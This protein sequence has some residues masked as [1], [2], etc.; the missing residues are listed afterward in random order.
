MTKKMLLAAFVCCMGL[1]T[2]QQANANSWRVNSDKRANANFLDLNAAM[3]TVAEGDTIYVDKGCVIATEQTINKSVTIIGPG[4]FIGENDADEAFFSNVI[5][6]SA[7]NVKLTGLHTA[8]IY[9]RA[10]S[11]I[12]ERCRVTGNITAT[13]DYEADEA[14]IRSCFICKGFIS[15]LGANGSDK[16]EILNN[17]IVNLETAC[18]NISNLQNALID[19]NFLWNSSND[20][21]SDIN[22]VT[23]STISNN[24][25]YRTNFWY[26]SNYAI[27]NLDITN[28]NIITHNV[29]N[30]PTI[31]HEKHPNNLVVDYDVAEIVA[32]TTQNIRDTYYQL[33]DVEA[34]NYDQNGQACGPFTGAYP[35]VI[36][37]YPLYVPRIE[38][39]TIPSQ[40]DASGNLKV[41]MVI[42]NQ[43]K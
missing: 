3:S 8:N 37:G 18:D 42:K 10:N 12:I 32:A 41:H 9:I 17:I 27:Q 30:S 33:K 31:V 34:L 16:W 5:I 26:A 25:I 36:S 2:V 4:Y 22:G 29:L 6:I 13:E 43:N 35:Y 15:G 23:S 1:C 39:I 11:V 20:Y 19:H 24:I 28:N 38:S 14:S 7:D 40:P 21:F